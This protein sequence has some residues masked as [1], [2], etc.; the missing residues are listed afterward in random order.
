MGTA[1]FIDKA[2][3][4]STSKGEKFEL[5]FSEV[6][7]SSGVP[8][9]VSSLV[10]R[11]QSMGQCDLVR[12]LPSKKQIEVMELKHFKQHELCLSHIQ[13]LRLTRTCQ[14]LSLLMNTPTILIVKK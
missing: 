8:M 7:H 13:K 2:S 14:Y 3:D 1:P 12:F 11:S 5:T 6:F 4:S 10:L 9:L